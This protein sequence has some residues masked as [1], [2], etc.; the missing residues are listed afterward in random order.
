MV[1]PKTEIEE[2][3]DFVWHNPH[4]FAMFRTDWITEYFKIDRKKGARVRCVL[5]ER[6]DDLREEY[7]DTGEFDE[8]Y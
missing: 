6:V 3:A 5:A 7:F 4:Y 2:M 8:E 1:K